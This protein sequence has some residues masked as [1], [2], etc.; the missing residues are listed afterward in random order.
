VS[1]GFNHSLA[2]KN[3]QVYAWGRDN[4]HQIEV[5]PEALSDVV[6]IDAGFNHNIAVKTDGS[7]VTW[8][9]N[10]VGESYF[11]WCGP[12][13]AISAGDNDSFALKEDPAAPC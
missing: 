3:G 5:P 13:Y 9:S 2:L 12:V 10:F 7:V 6:G 1:A 4:F 11:P 8:G